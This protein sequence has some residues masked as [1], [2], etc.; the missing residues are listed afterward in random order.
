MNEREYKDSQMHLN[1]YGKSVLSLEKANQ[2]D[3]AQT[4]LPLRTK[5]QLDV[6][7]TGLKSC[8]FGQL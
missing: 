3:R 6:L 1:C 7:V 8:P 4:D 2:L 5:L